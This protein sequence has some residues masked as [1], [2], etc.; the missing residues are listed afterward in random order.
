[1]VYFSFVEHQI[2]LVAIGGGDIAAVASLPG[3]EMTVNRAD[4]LRASL[5]EEDFLSIFKFPSKKILV[6]QHIWVLS[7]Y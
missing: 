1:M 3:G 2:S 5:N 7:H 4:T 6:Y